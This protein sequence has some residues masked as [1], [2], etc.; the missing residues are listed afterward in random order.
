MQTS[1]LYIYYVSLAIAAIISVMRFYLSDAPMRVLSVLLSLTFC[2]EMLSFILLKQE[3][4]QLRYPVIH[5]YSIIQLFLVVLFFLLAIKPYHQRKLI[6]LAVTLCPLIG[7]LNIF[8]L[9]PVDSINSNMLMFES[10][11]VTT[12]CLYYIYREVKN[13]SRSNL[14]TSGYAQIVL[15]LLLSW[16]TTF[17]FWAFIELLYHEEWKYSSTII[18]AHIIINILVYAGIAAVFYFYPKKQ[19][20][21]G[22]S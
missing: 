18:N 5:I 2:S 21:H 17:F 1:L 20:A 7:L 15:I 4:Y 19:I 11:V 10:F 9:Q 3:E 14:F 22:N 8:F 13:Y 6:I 12:L 16:S